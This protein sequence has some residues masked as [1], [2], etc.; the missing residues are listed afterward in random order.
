MA[1]LKEVFDLCDEFTKTWKTIDKAKIQYLDYLKL[2]PICH[3][4]ATLDIILRYMEGE[5]LKQIEEDVITVPA[6]VDKFFVEEETGKEGKCEDVEEEPKHE[7]VEEPVVET[8]KRTYHRINQEL[9]IEL[10][11]EIKRKWRGTTV[12]ELQKYIR[13]KY[14]VT[15]ETARSFINGVTYG[16]ISKEYFSVEKGVVTH[17]KSYE[18][19]VDKYTSEMSFPEIYNDISKKL[20]D[21]N[22]D[23]FALIDDTT[24]ANDI[25]KIAA[26]R[27][28]MFATSQFKDI[29]GGVK[30]VLIADFLRKFDTS[31]MK[32]SEQ[33]RVIKKE[34]EITV[35]AT[36]IIGVRSGK[37]YPS[38]TERFKEG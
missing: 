10:S 8:K 30:E 27:K 24:S 9:A 22:G 1:E 16:D 26:V 18:P 34:Y 25:T 4:K 7:V 36:Q 2:E 17:P 14:G 29:G 11:K 19:L 6:S 13:E 20:V 38:I 28:Q 31:K 37:T 15:A 12:K 5:S 21:S 32:T 35:T 3:V 23:I 33:I